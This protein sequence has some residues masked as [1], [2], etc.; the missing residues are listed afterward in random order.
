M[1]NY[2]IIFGF[3]SVF[4]FLF[5]IQIGRSKSKNTINFVHSVTKPYLLIKTAV[6]MLCIN[7]F[8][9][10]SLVFWPHWRGG[11]GAGGGVG[12]EGGGG[13]TLVSFTTKDRTM[14]IA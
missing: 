7:I 9:C 2:I 13:G 5:S 1:S 10:T 14:N 3:E 8:N 12:G 11:G 4:N 6:K